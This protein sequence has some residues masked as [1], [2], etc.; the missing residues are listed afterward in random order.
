MRREWFILQMIFDLGIPS[1]LQQIEE[2]L[3]T[4]HNIRVYVK[5]DDLIHPVISGNKWRKLKLNFEKFIQG[6]YERIVTFGGAF[7]NHIAAVAE[8][9]KLGEIPTTGII[10][11]DELSPDSNDTLRKAFQNGMQ[12]QFVSRE[13]Y[14]ER[15]ERVY[16]EELR[17]GLGNILLIEEGG[18]NFLGT[19]GISE[20]LKELPFEPDFM[21]AATGTGT[22]AAGLLLASEN[23]TVVSVPV[24]KNGAFIAEEIEKML[25]LATFDN[26][27]AAE[28]MSRLQLETGFHFG[29]YGRCTNELVS[30]I[31][32]FYKQH[33]IPLD[34][35]YTAKMVSAFYHHVELGKIPGGSSVVLLHTGGL[36]GTSSIKAYLD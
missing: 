22:T 25:R 7:S 23:M 33:H 10:R 16:H 26:D 34:Q 15:Y 35:V 28:K 3:F 36:Q 18:A 17:C 5:R 30:L 2:P 13:K 1:P 11:G 31:N 21:F 4:K 14:A 9:G 32:T 20:V 24:M 27:L 29:G 6:K 19:L 12:L 8:L